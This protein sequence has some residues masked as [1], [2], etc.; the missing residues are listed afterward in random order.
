MKGTYDV[1]SAEANSQLEK[2]TLEHQQSM[3]ELQEKYTSLEKDHDGV[4]QQ[5]TQLESRVS[6]LEEETLDL[7]QL[8]QQLNQTVHEKITE[9]GMLI[10]KLSEREVQLARLTQQISHFQTSLDHYRDAVREERL[11]EKQAFEDECATLKQQLTAER[12]IA[13]E[14]TEKNNQLQQSATQLTS[15]K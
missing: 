1:M 5:R 8:N 7:N 10:D 11:L 15:E 3:D 9:A 13:R 12:H 14:A 4:V 2:I 6:Q